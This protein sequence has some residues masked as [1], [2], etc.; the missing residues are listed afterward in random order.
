[1]A[2]PKNNRGLRRLINAGHWSMQGLLSA[3]RHEAA[4][5][6]EVGL[7]ALLLPVGLWLGEDGVEKALLA[8]SLLIVLLVELLNSAL[9][10]LADRISD[11]RHPLAG[12][13]KDQ[14]SAAVF[15]ALL[16]VVVTWGLVLLV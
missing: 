16:L 5:R 12:R 6:Q 3:Y 7:V 15:V 8:G 2:K 11:E 4:F 10:N 1:M 14:G 13:A 9:E